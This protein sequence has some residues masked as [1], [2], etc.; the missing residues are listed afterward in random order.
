MELALQYL[1]RF[2]VLLLIL[3]MHEFAHAFAAHLNG[4]DTAKAEGRYTLNP[5]R[6]FDMI[7]LI[8]FLLVGFGWAKPVPV[9]PYNYR[10]YKKG[11]IWVA[12]AGVIANFALAFLFY[13]LFVITWEYLYPLAYGTAFILPVKFLLYCCLYGFILDLSLFAFNLIPVYPLDG[14][15]LMD[16]LVKRKSKGYYEY[17]RVGYYVLLGLILF[18][19]LCSRIPALKFLDI[20]GYFMDFCVKIVGYPISWLW[21]LIFGMDLRFELWTIIA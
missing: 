4:D 6:H 11:T 13:P 19:S 9:N 10:D 14:F 21:D 12:V 2:T 3:P 5:F 20:F 8:C 7:G 17:K 18:S 15:R 1:A 16:A